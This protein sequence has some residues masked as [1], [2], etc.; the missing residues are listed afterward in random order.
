MEKISAREKCPVDF[1]GSITGN[2]KIVLLENRVDH[3]PGKPVNLELEHVLGSMPAKVFRMSSAKLSA[4]TNLSISDLI[5]DTK[6][7]IWLE[8]SLR[9]ILRLVSVGSKRFLTNKVDRSVTG[10]IG[11]QQCVG[12]LQVPVADYALVALSYFDHW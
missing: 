2:G 5:A 4:Q 3:A 1:V 7:S 8:S 6:P 10:L 12:P 9:N 11:Q